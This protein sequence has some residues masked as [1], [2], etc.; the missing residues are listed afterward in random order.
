MTTKYKNR[1]DPV[2][3]GTFTGRGK[4]YKQLLAQQTHMDGYGQHIVLYQYK[5]IKLI[6]ALWLHK[7]YL[8][9]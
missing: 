1:L 2:P 3:E 6:T 4:C 9:S 8:Y 7:R 5:F